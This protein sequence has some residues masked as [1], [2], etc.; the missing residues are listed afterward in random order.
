[1]TMPK[2]SNAFF[3][4][5]VFYVFCGMMWGMHMGSS[6]DFTMAPAHAHLNLLGWVT[7]ALFGTY[8]T[9]AAGSYSMKLAWI[10]F[11]VSAAGVLFMIPSLAMYLADQ[12]DKSIIPFI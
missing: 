4:M 8:Y 3:A 2:V 7:M 11:W 1:M 10:N 6:E 9:L 12:T 5:G